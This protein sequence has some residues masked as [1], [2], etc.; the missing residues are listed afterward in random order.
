MRE[1]GIYTDRMVSAGG[2]PFF[3]IKRNEHIVHSDTGPAFSAF[4]QMIR[5]CSV[6]RPALVPGRY[7]RPGTAGKAAGGRE[8]GRVGLNGILRGA[9]G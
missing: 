6:F 2:V 1:S 3:C 7:R 8:V 4:D 5:I 9:P